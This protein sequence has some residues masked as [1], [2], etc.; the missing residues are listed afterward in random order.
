MKENKKSALT[1]F[2]KA[3]Y[4]FAYFMVVI[5]SIFILPLFLYIKHFLIMS[6]FNILSYNESPWVLLMVLPVISFMTISVLFLK[7]KYAQGM[8]LFAKKEKEK[9]GKTTFVHT[10][11]GQTNK[12][13]VVCIFVIFL[14]V[15]I[16]AIILPF[17]AKTV[18]LQQG[19]MIR[20][21]LLNQPCEHISVSQYTNI[22]IGI[23]H[24][25]SGVY[26][27]E[28]YILNVSF[29]T[30]NGQNDFN[31]GAFRDWNTAFTFLNEIPPDICTVSGEE[32]LNMFLNTTNLSKQQEDLL[33]EIFA[34]KSVI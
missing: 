13:I 31:L 1:V 14:L 7:A 17:S 24:H 34:N 3:V 27:S 11:S 26:T 15:N 33:R 18:L 22:D 32:N 10:K 16:L 30:E 19:D 5:L 12:R 23:H 9:R 29:K 21:G 2:Q 25:I 28:K 4:I 6:D 20:Y 8:P